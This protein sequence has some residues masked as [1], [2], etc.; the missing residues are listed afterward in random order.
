MPPK[1]INSERNDISTDPSPGT[2][3]NA[4]LGAED[5]KGSPPAVPPRGEE[6]D[7]GD[8]LAEAPDAD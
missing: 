3:E 2:D 8:V 7:D 5:G 4:N 6:E 1:S